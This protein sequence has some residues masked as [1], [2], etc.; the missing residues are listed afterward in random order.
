VLIPGPRGSTI[1]LFMDYHQ[2][3]DDGHPKAASWTSAGLRINWTM[4]D[5]GLQP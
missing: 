2:Y 5:A 3:K 4:P 1:D